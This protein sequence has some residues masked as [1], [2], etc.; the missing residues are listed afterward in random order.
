MKPSIVI[1]V[2]SAV[3]T[4]GQYQ[5]TN[6]DQDGSRN[7]IQTFEGHEGVLLLDVADTI[8]PGVAEYISDG[9]S[10][11]SKGNMAAVIIRLDTPGGLLDATRSI[12]QSIMESPVPVI[13]YVA[14]G[15]ARAG[16]AG[17]FITLA[18]NIA[19]MAP[20]ANIGAAHPVGGGGE[21]PEKGG[22]HI[23]QKIENDAVAFIESIAER[24]G[25][26]KE[27]AKKA[28]TQSVSVPTNEA[29]KLH[30]ID[31]T[32]ST[33]DELLKKADGM[34][35]ELNGKKYRLGLGSQVIHRFPMSSV[36]R[37]V[38]TF[39]HPNILYIL[40]MIGVLGILGEIYH[41]GA[42]FPGVIGGICL[43]LAFIGMQTLP[44]NLGG[45]ALIL[46][47]IAMF[48]GELFVTSHGLL[49]IGGS[50]ALAIGSILLIDSEDP[51]LRISR[52]AIFAASG[53]MLAFSLFI[54]YK[55]LK[56]HGMRFATGIQGLDG[57]EGIV[58]KSLEPGVEGTVLVHG[59]Y[60]RAKAD[61]EIKENDKVIVTAVHGMVLDVTAKKA[62]SKGD[63]QGNGKEGNN[64][65]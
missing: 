24:R 55:V 34:I 65:D 59:E 51:A 33:L 5:A 46:L 32:A 8:N 57:E 26:N 21:D 45:L 16:S 30:I 14:P 3:L 40:M 13:V 7:V 42:I 52:S 54:V 50:I 12:V 39:S 49:A 43:I 22:K 20:G 25:R 48:V 53:T 60:W 18:A 15:G 35:V 19:A 27:W 10:K 62:L 17:T 44:I 29:L 28:V 41:P 1:A 64:K 61:R 9:I 56:T 38:S 47:A 4:T 37:F 58:K 6:K 11:A 36:Q 2:L 63:D 31:L 23:A